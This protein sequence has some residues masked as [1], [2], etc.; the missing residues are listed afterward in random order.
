MKDDNKKKSIQT[1]ATPG[2]QDSA[3]ENATPENVKQETKEL[4]NIGPEG[5]QY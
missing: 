3:Y 5:R 2:L 1:K 4:N